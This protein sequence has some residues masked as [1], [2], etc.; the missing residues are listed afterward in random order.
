M[1]LEDQLRAC[2]QELERR[3][4]GDDDAACALEHV[5]MAVEHLERKPLAKRTRAEQDR[6]GSVKE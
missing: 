3:A 2:M 1:R 4:D 6:A 5:R